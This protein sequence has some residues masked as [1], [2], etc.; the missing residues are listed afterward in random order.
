MQSSIQVGVNGPTVWV[1]VAGRGSFLN[2]G[3][4]K[5]FAREMVNRGHRE[6]VFDLEECV[7]M[8]STFMGTMA[9]MA[10]RLKELGQ[11][12]VHVIHCGPRS[13]DLLSGLGL[14]QIF[15]IQEDGAEAPQCEALAKTNGEAGEK[16]DATKR[17]QAGTMLEAHKALCEAAPNNLTRFKDVLEY[18][19]QD[20][21]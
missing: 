21:Q 7:M 4:L 1:R 15:D 10:L 2:S 12:R 20:L 19:K 11:G 18:L 8:D 16:T 17:E 5:E 14:D 13:R 6:F 3:S 9:G